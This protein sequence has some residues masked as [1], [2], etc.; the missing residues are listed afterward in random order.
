M[1]YLVA[2]VSSSVRML[3]LR[4]SLPPN[5]NARSTLGAIPIY[6]VGEWFIMDQVSS[7][8]FCDEFEAFMISLRDLKEARV[9]REFRD[10]QRQFIFDVS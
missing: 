4:M 9:R 1:F 5:C 10:M 7:G 8:M 3:C 2:S 6:G